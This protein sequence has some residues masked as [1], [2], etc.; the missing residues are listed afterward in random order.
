[1]LVERTMLLNNNEKS[2]MNIDYN[3]LSSHMR[4]K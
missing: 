1:M 4:W 3:L 2:I